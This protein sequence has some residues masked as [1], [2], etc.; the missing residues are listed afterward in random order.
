MT[1]LR[2]VDAARVLLA[3]IFAGLR[4]V[5]AAVYIV[6]D[7]APVRFAVYAANCIVL[8]AM[9]GRFALNYRESPRI[10][11]AAAAIRA[12]GHRA[13]GSGAGCGL[14]RQVERT[15]RGGLNRL[16]HVA[17]SLRLR[18]V[19]VV[20]RGLPQPGGSAR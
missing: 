19:N 7:A 13:A 6:F 1:A 3:W 10:T 11:G 16:L 4:M 20:S 15:R 5:H 14:F 12:S 17:P 9:C 2:S 8:A 18:I